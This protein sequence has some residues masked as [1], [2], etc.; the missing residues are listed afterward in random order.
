MQAFAKASHDATMRRLEQLVA[1]MH[2][3]FSA[4]LEEGLAASAL[5]AADLA[6]RFE[7]LRRDAAQTASN[8]E[9]QLEAERAE[10]AAL[11]GRLEQTKAELADLRRDLEATT[12]SATAA[13]ATDSSP[14][15]P[16]LS[17]P[18]ATG[19]VATKA[20]LSAMSSRLEAVKSD[21]FSL[22]SSL[23]ETN[24]AVEGMRAEAARSRRDRGPDSLAQED[25]IRALGEALTQTNAELAGLR[26]D[27]AGPFLLD[28][29]EEQW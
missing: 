6:Q 14:S 9:A 24:A 20:D 5:A 21:I 27:I 16:S 18:Y 12:S 19:A 7:D 4:K 11:H 8:L 23:D 10:R 25:R 29:D 26:R 3:R 15:M 28:N 1:S 13:S 17:S 2:D 22:S